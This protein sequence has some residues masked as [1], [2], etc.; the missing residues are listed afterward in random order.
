MAENFDKNMKEIR[1]MM[2][3]MRE[4]EYAI[5]NPDL[6]EL[7]EFTK[8]LYLKVLCM[9][10]QYENEPSEMQ[11]LFLKRIVKGMGVE[12]PAEEYLRRALEI[13]DEDMR[14]FFNLLKENKIKYYFAM[15]GLLLVS[16]GDTQTGCYE[17]LAEV[18]ELM[19]ICK[20][21]LDYI[22]LVAGSALQQQS[23]LYD[24]AKELLNE[25]VEKVDYAP[26]IRNFYA[27]AI[28]DSRELVHFSVPDRKYS[29][30]IAIRTKYREKKV[31]LE[32]LDIDLDLDWNIDIEKEWEFNSC[33]EVIFE[34]CHFSGR[35]GWRSIR[36]DG[37]QKVYIHKCRFSDFRG[38]IV[39]KRN[40]YHMQIEECEFENCYCS[41][42]GSGAYGIIHSEYG[43]HS[44][45]I[46][47]K[48]V[49]RNCGCRSYSD[50]NAIFANGFCEVYGCRFYNC[51]HYNTEYYKP[52]GR[53][54]D[55][56]T[57]FLPNTK[58]SDNEIVN[59]A[60]LC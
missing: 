3:A 33:E 55:K 12:E 24:E 18:I 17:Y 34:N 6:T 59:S 11:I 32:N 15:D 53:R 7:D 54:Y 14:E 4:E 31:V 2:A 43:D 8:N 26:Y 51:Y 30:D 39:E 1:K 28:K 47:K 42:E 19:G 13:S 40:I 25:R 46:I 37:C 58:E 10:L 29:K 48:S 38:S 52:T 22:C 49:F 5:V 57:L 50:H 36:F 27:G 23:S 21:D 41:G 45:T 16:M 20:D 60:K 44:I 35:E 56:G 9:V